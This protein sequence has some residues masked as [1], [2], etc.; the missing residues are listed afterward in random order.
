[1]MENLINDLLDIAK[2]ERN[3]FQFTS[4]YFNLEDVI[5]EAF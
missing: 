1:M 2:L 4:D 3:T 5:Y